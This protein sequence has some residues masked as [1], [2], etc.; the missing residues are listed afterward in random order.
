MRMPSDGSRPLMTSQ[1]ASLVATPTPSG[2][3][4]AT[5]A[6][7]CFGGGSGAA[8]GRLGAGLRACAATDTAEAASIAAT[9]AILPIRPAPLI[10]RLVLAHA[11]E[12]RRG[13]VPS[14]RNRRA[15]LDQFEELH[16]RPRV[17]A[18]DPQH[19][20]RHAERVLF[21]DAAHGHA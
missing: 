21:F 4:Q 2:V 1:N 14:S 11:G 15:Q 6:G 5:S 17:V 8:A 19:R 12:V 18:K 7:S 13:D 10:R 3:G 16:P 9:T 20:A